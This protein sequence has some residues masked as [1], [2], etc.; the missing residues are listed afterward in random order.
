[1]LQQRARSHGYQLMSCLHR[2]DAARDVAQ[3]SWLGSACAL[4]GY[5]G[6][7]LRMYGGVV[8]MGPDKC[9]SSECRLP[10]SP[11]SLFGHESARVAMGAMASI[12]FVNLG[13][14]RAEI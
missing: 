13:Q 1:M 9:I 2:T 10:A 11:M 8:H 12:Y 7:D 3:S 6:Q 14:P 5:V 4:M